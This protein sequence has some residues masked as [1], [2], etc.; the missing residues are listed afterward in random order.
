MLKRR[1]LVVGG[2]GLALGA[3]SAAIAATPTIGWVAPDTREAAAPFFRALYEGLRDRMKSSAPQIVERYAPKGPDDVTAATQDLVRQGV[4]LIV[5]QGTATLSAVRAAQSVPVVFA[6]SG[7][8][9]LAGAAQSLAQPGGNATG[10]SFMSVELMPKRIDYLRQ[11]TPAAR[12]FALLSNARHPGEERE[13]QSCLEAVASHG[14]SVAVHRVRTLDEVPA[15]TDR[16]LQEAQALLVLSSAFM[17][18]ATPGIAAQCM[19]K[20][21]PMVAGWASMARAGALMSYGP[22]LEAGTRRVAYY[23]ER[24]LAGAPPSSLPIELPTAFELMLNRRT[25]A[26]IDVPLP[27]TLLAQA[28]QVID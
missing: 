3:R 27:A 2:A 5:A 7:D 25:A 18:N 16:A 4:S 20:K 15:A 14:I 1:H 19:A 10:I 9:V 6:F 11:A 26:A 28:E 22:N 21:I 17:V 8:P 13:I 23:V 12:R 24:I